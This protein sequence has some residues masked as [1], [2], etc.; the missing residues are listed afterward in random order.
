MAATQ[1]TVTTQS[2]AAS[3]PPVRHPISDDERNEL[4]KR[5]RNYSIG[6][7]VLI[8]TAIAGTIALMV[9][10]WI[11]TSRYV[12]DLQ[13][14][15]TTELLI[16]LLARG[17]AFGATGIGTIVALLLFARACL[18]QAARFR[19]RWFSAPVFNEAMELYTR[20]ADGKMTAKDV[21]RLFE[22]WNAV[23]DSPFAGIRLRSKPQRISID[24]SRGKVVIGEDGGDD[25]EPEPH[26][27]GARMSMTR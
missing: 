10:S 13:G 1:T 20:S 8:G 19:K 9:A 18:D 4:A 21:I 17:T 12:E 16:L 24:A 15:H 25:D 26:R 2:T 23:V 5:A 11:A 14:P 6:G 22:A 3:L 7:V 27:V